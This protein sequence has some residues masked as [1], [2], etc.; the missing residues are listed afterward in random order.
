MAKIY[1]MQAL[2]KYSMDETLHSELELNPDSLT[3]C[4]GLIVGREYFLQLCPII[5]TFVIMFL[6]YTKFY[7]ILGCNLIV[8]IVTAL[9]CR[10][11]PLYKILTLSMLSIFCGMFILRFFIHF[12]IMGILA[13]TLFKNG[14]ILVYF[15]I[16]RIISGLISS[17]L[18][19]YQQMLKQ[20]NEIANYV[21]NGGYERHVYNIVSFFSANHK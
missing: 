2:L 18:T 8:G 20:N 19:G 21:L 10:I 17:L 6:G 5:A 14:W 4:E 12:A 1:Q 16:A 3:T 11:F 13:F 15:I 9:I 7:Q